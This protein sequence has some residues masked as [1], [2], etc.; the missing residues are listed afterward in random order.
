M[1]ALTLYQTYRELHPGMGQAVA[2]R[3]I[4]RKKEEGVSL[5]N[6]IEGIKIPKY[7]LDYEKDLKACHNI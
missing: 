2:E 1:T 5:R 7:L 6:P 3:T 4:L